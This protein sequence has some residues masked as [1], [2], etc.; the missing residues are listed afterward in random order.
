MFIHTQNYCYTYILSQQSNYIAIVAVS[1]QYISNTHWKYYKIHCYEI[2]S[3]TKHF[4][5]Q[6]L[7]VFL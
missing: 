3:E 4:L 5:I 1:T 6:F 2:S 7:P